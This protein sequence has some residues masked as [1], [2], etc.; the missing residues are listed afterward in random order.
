MIAYFSN[1][2]TLFQSVLKDLSL[3]KMVAVHSTSIIA[4]KAA[5]FIA[6]TLKLKKRKR[7]VLNLSSKFQT[8]K[9]K[10]KDFIFV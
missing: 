6:K 9:K 2:I 4:V 7:F 1:N 5:N 10:P 8:Y 3:W